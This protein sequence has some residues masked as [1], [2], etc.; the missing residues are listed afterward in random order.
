MHKKLLLLLATAWGMS[1][2][3]QSVFA[4]THPDY[5][6]LVERYEIQYGR[7]A[8]GIHTH[9]RPY[10]RRNIVQLA[11]SLQAQGKV[12]LN[13]RDQFNL[14]YLRNDSW[15]WAQNPDQQGNSRKPIL[16]ALFR[17]KSDFYHFRN[18]DFE[19]HAS[20][21]L[22]WSV[23]KEKDNDNTLFVNTRG[24]EIRGMIGRKVGFYS[25]FADNQAS[26]ASFVK[27]RILSVRAE[28]P[29]VPGE[30]LTKFFKGRTD[31]YDFLS[32]R[33]YI[34]FQA[35]KFIN[36]QFGHDRNFIGNGYRSM[37]LSDASSPYLFLKLTTQIGRFQYMNLFSEIIDRQIPLPYG[38]LPA[39]KFFAFHHLSVNITDNLNVGIFETE[40]LGRGKDQGYFDLSY[41]NPIIFYRAVEQ[42]K[43]SPDN[44]ILGMD[45][46]ANFLRRF[47][48]YGQLAL[49]EFVLREVRAR[50]GSWVNKF[51]IQLGGKYINALGIKNLDLQAEMNLARPYTYSHISTVSNFIH[52]N[53]PLAHP[54]GANFRELIGVARYQPFGRLQLTGTL[55]VAKYGTDGPNQNWG[56]SP[57]KNYNTRQQDLN[58]SIGQGVKT[59]LLLADFTASYMLKHNLWLDLK[60]VARRLDSANDA[61]DRN[62][63]YL[64][65]TLRWNAWQRLMTF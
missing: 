9:M 53:Q 43:N 7:F 33:G 25:Y 21:V 15:E 17:K 36:I 57:L 39:K 51:G 4:P 42:Q 31:A 56:G 38:Q 47:S 10:L 61:L 44:A 40:V 50:N 49:D 54:L 52:Y 45:F 29:F 27:D 11:D 48:I 13:D 59:D 32:A 6:H 26:F 65:T 46:K 34:T 1:A 64:T 23:G 3:A 14:D 22:Y 28:E 18:K 60:A 19:I 41:L 35:V 12:P 8:D 62:T 58:N 37:V 16:G 2:Q 63:V 5:T 30:G 20:P 55:V 24:L